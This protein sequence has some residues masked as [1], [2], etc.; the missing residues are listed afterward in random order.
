[1]TTHRPAPR[2]PEWVRPQHVL[3]EPV[4][5]ALRLGRSS[6]A[7]IA[8]Q[9]VMAFP[10][11]FEFQIVTHCRNADDGWDPMHGLSGLRR[12][13]GTPLDVLD[14]DHVR[15]R[16]HFADGSSADNLGPPIVPSSQRPARRLLQPIS[17]E[18]GGL[19]ARMVYW[20]W[21]LPPPGPVIFSCEWPRCEIP[22][23][24]R[25]I[26]ARLILEA[27]ARAEELWPLDEDGPTRDG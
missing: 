26:P 15:L 1:M 24:R 22:L 23:T 9:H 12:R 7:A 20:V 6:I 27:A 4:P 13:A 5:V 8:L 25:E 3:G 11:G 2:F 17:G 19:M 16:L 14:E 21:P 10:S 18:A